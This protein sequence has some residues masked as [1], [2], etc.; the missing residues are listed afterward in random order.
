MLNLQYQK[1]TDSFKVAITS[2]LI[3]GI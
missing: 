1:T 2:F 3:D